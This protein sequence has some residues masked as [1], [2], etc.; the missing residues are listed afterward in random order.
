[1]VDN[2][3]GNLNVGGV[4]NSDDDPKRQGF[5]VYSNWNHTRIQ[6][7]RYYTAKGM[8]R[9]MKKLLSFALILGLTLIGAGNSLAA[10]H[11]FNGDFTGCYLLWNYSSPKFEVRH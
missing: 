7:I 4:R 6:A 8:D 2:E 3:L 1:V 5:M 11:N 9:A 10:V